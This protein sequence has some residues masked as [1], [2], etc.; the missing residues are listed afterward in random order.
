MAASNAKFAEPSPGACASGLGG[1]FISRE[2]AVEEEGTGQQWL[3]QIQS[4]LSLPVVGRR[5][6]IWGGCDYDLWRKKEWMAASN[7][8]FAEPSCGRKESLYLGRV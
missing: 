8:R 5:V 6:Y 7:A 4:L 1:E 2:R 3:L